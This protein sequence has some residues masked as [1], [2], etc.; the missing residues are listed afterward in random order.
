MEMKWDIT[1]SSE[2]EALAA[3]DDDRLTPTDEA[4]ETIIKSGLEGEYADLA[5]EWHQ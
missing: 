3:L 5:E 1:A 4:S 2:S